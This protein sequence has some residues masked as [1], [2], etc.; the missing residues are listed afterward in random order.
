M[1]VLEKRATTEDLAGTFVIETKSVWR[2][3]RKERAMSNV[4]HGGQNAEVE[5][6][7][8]RWRSGTRTT[9]WPGR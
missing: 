2:A 1:R 8:K 5:R 4:E 6:A 3:G 9:T 7:V